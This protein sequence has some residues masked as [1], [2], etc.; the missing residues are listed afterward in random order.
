[1]S[2]C[3]ADGAADGVDPN[4]HLEVPQWDK[5]AIHALLFH[6]I[7][8][9]VAGSGLGHLEKLCDEPS[10][11]NTTGWSSYSSLEDWKQVTSFIHMSVGKIT[12]C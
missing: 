2:P 1:M 10:D 12:L 7:F 11:R 3:T 8:H 4:P 9:V 6:N 5:I